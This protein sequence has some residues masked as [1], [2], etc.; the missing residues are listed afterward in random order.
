MTDRYPLVKPSAELSTG[1]EVYRH[2]MHNLKIPASQNHMLWYNAVKK[3][4]ETPDQSPFRGDIPTG[5]SLEILTLGGKPINGQ[6][7]FT[8]AEEYVLVSDL[9]DSAKQFLKLPENSRP[10]DKVFNSNFKEYDELSEYTKRSN[11]LAAMSVAK[12]IPSYLMGTMKKSRF[13]ER[14]VVELIF[15]ILE[16]PSGK[17]AEFFMAMNNSNWSALAYIRNQGVVNGDILA[18]FHEQNDYDFF[19]KDYGT[20]F[21]TLLYTHAILGQDPMVSY[22]RLNASVYDAQKIAASMRS[23]MHQDLQKV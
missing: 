19:N 20:I 3:K 2:L 1:I 9:A 5:T 23:F 6:Y 12:S 8:G 11:E 18:N 16:N 14:D 13:S 10:Q 22:G 21:P 4:L 7:K 17:E 15:E